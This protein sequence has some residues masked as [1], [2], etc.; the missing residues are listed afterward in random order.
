MLSRDVR[1]RGVIPVGLVALSIILFREGWLALIGDFLGV[2]HTLHGWRGLSNGLRV[3]VVPEG[4][5][6]NRFLY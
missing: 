1:S 3:L 6:T 2:Q 5:R 4:I